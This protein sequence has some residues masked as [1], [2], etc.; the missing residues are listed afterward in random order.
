MVIVKPERLGLLLSTILALCRCGLSSSPSV[1][2]QPWMELPDV[3]KHLSANSMT[4]LRQQPS[5][6]KEIFLHIPPGGSRIPFGTIHAKVN[7]ESADVAM[8]T[9]IGQDG[10]LVRVDLNDKGGF[11]MRP[12]RNSVELEYQD[13]FGRATYCSFLLSFA[14]PS[15]N[16]HGERPNPVERAPK[17]ESG[18]LFAVVVGISH[19]LK[20]GQQAGDLKYADRDARAVY[21]FLRSPAGGGVAETDA[22]LLLNEQATTAKVRNALFTFL[23]RPQEQDTVVIYFAGHGIPDP[24]DPRNL[25]FLTSDAKLDD[26]AGTALAMYEMQQVF[27]RVLKAR[28]VVTFA[29]TCHGYGF[30]GERTGERAESGN[31]L[32][33]QYIEHYAGHGERAVITASDINETSYEDSKWGEGHGVFTY[34]LLRGLGGEADLN[35]DGVV[36]AGEIFTYLRKAV[37]AA[38]DNKQNPRALKGLASAL[39]ISTL[40]NRRA[41]AG[42]GPNAKLGF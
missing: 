36:T 32:I 25:Y 9:S 15:R 11:P 20:G 13:E 16:S 30:T 12:G 23:A 19:F 17:E 2:N 8:K 33:N 5:K 7:T 35:H 29:D 28:R 24:R 21:D 39:T 14:N 38:T 42:G 3:G 40:R 31:N 34:Y 37:P 41:H 26:M 6:I 22:V 18:R 4:A 1:D 10:L 27:A